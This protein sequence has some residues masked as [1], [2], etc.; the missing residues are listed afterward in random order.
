VAEHRI[1]QGLEDALEVDDAIAVVLG[2]KRQ[3]RKVGRVRGR[4]RFLDLEEQRIVI[5]VAEVE[6]QVGAPA[7]AA[8]AHDAVGD[9]GD[10]VSVQHDAVG[11]REVLGVLLERSD[12]LPARLVVDP[13]QDRRIV[14]EA[15]A[16]IVAPPPDLRQQRL[17]GV[18][19]LR[20]SGLRIQDAACLERARLV[21]DKLFLYQQKT[22]TPVYCPLPPLVVERLTAVRNE[23]EQFFFYEARVSAR[24]WSRAGIACFT[25][26]SRQ[27]SR[28]SWAGIPIAFATRLRCRCC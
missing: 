20:Y 5:P 16:A 12:D 10:P 9:V 4:G 19:L 21:N 24:A 15:P 13:R 28:R 23:N 22:G 7:D 6:R 25:K 27:R 1:A 17:A 11:G 8:D 2:A 26:C 3:R 18:L 14:D